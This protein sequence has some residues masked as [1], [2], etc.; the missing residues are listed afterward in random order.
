MQ[1]EK[2]FTFL[3]EYFNLMTK[4]LTKNKWTLD[5]YIWDSVMWFFNAPL[6]ID[7]PE[8]MA[9]KTA[10]EQQKAIK[11]LN[12]KWSKIINQN[13]N[14]R[15]WI[16]SWEAIHGNLWSK[17]NRINY[18]VIWD[19]VNLAS[20]LEWINKIYWTNIIISYSVYKTIKE[21]FVTRELD[22]IT[23]KWKSQKTKIFEL[24]SP[25]NKNVIDRNILK[26]YKNWL[27]FYYEANYEKAIIEFQKNKNDSPSMTLLNRCKLAKDWKIIIENWLYK[28]TQK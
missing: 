6:K 10:I 14:V 4:I 24:I 26:N 3:N 5:K 7:Y 20:R 17:D 13:L 23:V 27:K 25:K 21:D 18:T 2:L 15:I 22:T 11:I 8:F 1:A 12:I 16:H 9:C 19:N 28:I